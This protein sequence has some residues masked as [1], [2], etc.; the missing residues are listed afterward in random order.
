MFH[1]G[2][3]VPPPPPSAPLLQARER[4]MI[5]EVRVRV[6]E[7]RDEVRIRVRV[8]EARVG[9]W[10]GLEKVRGEVRVRG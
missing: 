3:P 4:L 10:L 9:L 8:G 1:D 5:T 7:A 2:R 6:G